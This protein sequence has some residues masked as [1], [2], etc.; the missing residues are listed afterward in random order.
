MRFALRKSGGELQFT[1]EGFDE[2]AKRAQ[3]HVGLALDLGNCTLIT[4]EYFRNSVLCEPS[5][6]PD[7][8]KRQSREHSWFSLSALACAT[9]DILFRRSANFLAMIFTSLSQVRPDAP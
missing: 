3:V 6:V 7:L 4:P 2:C 5:C 8:R 1:A 9:G